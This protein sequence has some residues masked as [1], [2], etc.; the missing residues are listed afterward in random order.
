[1][2]TNMSSASLD[3]GKPIRA[4]HCL[5]SH[6]LVDSAAG[7]FFGVRARIAAYTHMMKIADLSEILNIP[8]ASLYRMVRNRTL[9]YCRISSMIRLEPRRIL[10]WFDNR[11][12]VKQT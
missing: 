8:K 2:Q 1:M 12:C 7:P 9:P 11:E 6:F 10:E 5:S 3:S 4:A